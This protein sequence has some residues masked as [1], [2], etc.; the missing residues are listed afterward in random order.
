MVVARFRRRLGFTALAASLAAGGGARARELRKLR[1]G[2]RQWIG[3][4]WH[5]WSKRGSPER[6]PAARRGQPGA[7]R[8]VRPETRPG[9]EAARPRGQDLTREV[10]RSGIIVN[11]DRRTFLLA[12]SAAATLKAAPD[13]SATIL[14]SGNAIKI[15]KT[16]PDAK[17]GSLWVRQADLPRINDFC[18]GA[19]CAG[20]PERTGS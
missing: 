1:F 18:A 3:K 7:V 5:L 6:G 2:R 11:M 4:Q 10:V 15:D 17:D 12:A 8:R 9:Q 16:R 20:L 19:V 14:Y 13:T